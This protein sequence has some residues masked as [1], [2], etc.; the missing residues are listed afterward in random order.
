M[1]GTH[2]SDAILKNTKK[3]PHWVCRAQETTRWWSSSAGWG[4]SACAALE[5][6]GLPKEYS[7]WSLL[8]QDKVKWR[9]AWCKSAASELDT[10]GC[11]TPTPP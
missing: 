5:A 7:A 10:L 1:V 3:V 6:A 9:Q 4:R 11:C 8:A 2:C